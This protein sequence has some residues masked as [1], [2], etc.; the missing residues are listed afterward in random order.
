LLPAGDAPLVDRANLC[1]KR[2]HDGK[3]GTR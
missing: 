1:S 3:S 2:V